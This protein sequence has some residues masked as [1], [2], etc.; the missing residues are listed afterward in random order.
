MHQQGFSAAGGVLQADFIQIIQRVRIN[1]PEA[2]PSFI[3]TPDIAVQVIQQLL[4][5]GKLPIQVD[6]HKEEG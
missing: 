6:F 5:I 3:E 2:C 1:I 4:F